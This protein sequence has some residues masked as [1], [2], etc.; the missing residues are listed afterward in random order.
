MLQ[1][2]DTLRL[3]SGSQV[4][5]S[6]QAQYITSGVGCYAPVTQTTLNPCVFLCSSIA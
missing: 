1:G 5:T 3:S 6:S 2:L 4:H